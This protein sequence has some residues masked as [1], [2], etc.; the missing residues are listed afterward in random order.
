VQPRAVAIVAPDGEFPRGTKTSAGKPI[1]FDLAD[2]L[3]GPWRRLRIEATPDGVTAFWAASPTAEWQ[4]L[5]ALS[6][7][8]IAERLTKVETALGVALAPHPP[9]RWNPAAAVGLWCDQ[10]AMSARNVVLEV[11]P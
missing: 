8:K 2:D 11:L 6:A 3:P 1:Q 9:L 10:A 4:S 7:E 5:G